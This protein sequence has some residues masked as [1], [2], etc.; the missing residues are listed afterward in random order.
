MCDVHNEGTVSK[1]ELETFV[2]QVPIEIL[3]RHNSDTDL[4]SPLGEDKSP[5]GGEPLLPPENGE[6]VDAPEEGEQESDEE[7]EEEVDAYTN[8]DIAEQAFRDCDVENDGR[9]TY[10]EFKMWVERTPGRDRVY[11]VHFTNFWHK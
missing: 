4:L 10:E 6:H 3:H 1:A 2:N 9:L 8:H 7:Y 11:R 5:V